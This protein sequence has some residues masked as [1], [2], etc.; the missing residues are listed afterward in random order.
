MKQI[1][2][3]ILKVTIGSLFHYR[4]NT[5]HSNN[6]TENNFYGPVYLIVKP[7]KESDN[8]INSSS[9]IKGISKF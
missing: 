7:P 5:S 8:K 6:K 1:W 9:Q 3:S 4:N 2:E